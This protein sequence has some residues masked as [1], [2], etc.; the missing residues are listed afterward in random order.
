M[1]FPVN[2]QNGL[3]NFIVSLI[4]LIFHSLFLIFIWYIIKK[5]NKFEYELLKNEEAHK[6]FMQQEYDYIAKIYE[7]N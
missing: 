2:S 1:Y 4:S 7:E 6:K 5:C 3:I